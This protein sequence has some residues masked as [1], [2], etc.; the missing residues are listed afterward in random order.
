[1]TEKEYKDLSV[2]E[3]WNTLLDAGCGSAPMITLLSEKYPDRNYT[4]IDLTPKMIEQAKK[5][6]ILHAGY[7]EGL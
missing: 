2:K 4:G 6:N 5:K 7:S 1:M 3:P